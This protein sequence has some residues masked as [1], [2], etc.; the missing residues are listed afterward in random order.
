MVPDLEG[1][2]ALDLANNAIRCRYTVMG[3]LEDVWNLLRYRD[4]ENE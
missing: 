3:G 2:V 4:G 1:A